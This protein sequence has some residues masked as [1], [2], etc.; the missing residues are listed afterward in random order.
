MNTPASRNGE[1]DH[2]DHPSPHDR[3]GSGGRT[4]SGKAGVVAPRLPHER[5]ES[6]DSQTDINPG[7]RVIGEQAH[8][9]VTQGQ[10]DTDQRQQTLDELNH[11][12][13]PRSDPDAGRRTVAPGTPGAPG[14][15]RQR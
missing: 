10:Q 7:A 15:P 11:R 2:P 8:R 1:Q 4:Q 6:S 3:P 12:T 5:D 13:L 14:T 9:D